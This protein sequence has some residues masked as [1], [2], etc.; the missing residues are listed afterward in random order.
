M[1]KLSQLLALQKWSKESRLRR[2]SIRCLAKTLHIDATRLRNA[3]KFGIRTSL[4]KRCA[5][6]SAPQLQKKLRF[7]SDVGEILL[8]KFGK[9]CPS[10]RSVR[11]LTRH[12]WSIKPKPHP[13]HNT[14]QD[15]ATWL[16]VSRSTDKEIIVERKA[17][18]G[19]PQFVGKRRGYNVEFYP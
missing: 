19:T 6:K 3:V 9:A 7:A 10:Q 8:Q 2:K 11:R 17:V 16:R 5:V 14:M 18:H 12:V 15:T 13:Q 4:R 1:L